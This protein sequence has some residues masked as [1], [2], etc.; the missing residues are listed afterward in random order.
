MN[1]NS[2]DNNYSS[3]IASELSSLLQSSGLSS[4]SSTTTS[5][6]ATTVTGASS[7]SSQLSPFAQ[8]LST[9]QQLQQSNP[10]EY[11][12]VTK[13]IATNLTAAAQTAT[14]NGNTT[15]ANQLTQLA[16]DFTTASTG[17]QLPNIQDLAQALRGG[18]HRHH[19]QSSSNTSGAS[20]S[21]GSAGS[22]SASGTASSTNQALEQIL[23]A[24]ESLAT[25]GSVTAQQQSNSASTNPMSIIMNTLSNAGISLNSGS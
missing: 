3:N 11:A 19:V 25:N 1:I 9:L 18:A 8:L 7:D 16:K 15:Q 23:A 10:T 17:G 2:L 4:T 12:S 24:F 6:A 14:Q 21:D 20:D 5:T 13:Q 22:S